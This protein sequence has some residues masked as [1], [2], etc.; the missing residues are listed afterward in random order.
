MT[1]I[2]VV[3]VMGKDIAIVN[4]DAPV[5]KDYKS[6]KD[7]MIMIKN[8]AKTDFFCMNIEGLTE[9]FFDLETKLADNILDL[10]KNYH[11][12]VAFFGDTAKYTEGNIPLQEYIQEVNKGFDAFIVLDQEEAVKCL[13]KVSDE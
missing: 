2:D 1:M 5:I 3:P 6:A 8:N 11:M 7:F 13:T 10:Y 9:D 4:A 12:N